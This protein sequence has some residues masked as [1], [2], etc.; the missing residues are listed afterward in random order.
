MH[1]TAYGAD[2][3]PFT[4]EHLKQMEEELEEKAKGKEGWNCDGD[5]CRRA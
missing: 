3:F 1:L 2:A 4:E 5:V